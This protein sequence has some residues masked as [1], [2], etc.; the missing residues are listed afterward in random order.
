VITASHGGRFK[1]IGYYED[2][3][4]VVVYALLGSEAVSLISFRPASNKESKVLS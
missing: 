3:T 2:G 4:A 1:A